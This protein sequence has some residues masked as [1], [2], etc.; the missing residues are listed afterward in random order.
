MIKTIISATLIFLGIAMMGGSVAI[1][2][3]NV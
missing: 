1:V 3:V 2:M